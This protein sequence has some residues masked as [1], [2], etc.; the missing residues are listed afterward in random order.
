M[1]FISSSPFPQFNVAYRVEVVTARLQHCWAGRGLP[2][3]VM[4]LDMVPKI[5]CHCIFVLSDPG[6]PRTFVGDCMLQHVT[7]SRTLVDFARQPTKQR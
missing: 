6:V 2:I 7:Q 1:E 4:P 5:P 3:L